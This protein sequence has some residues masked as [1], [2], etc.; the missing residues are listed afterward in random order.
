MIEKTG[1]GRM[2]TLLPMWDS[3]GKRSTRGSPLTDP[4]VGKPH[5]IAATVKETLNEP[6]EPLSSAIREKMEARLGY[7]FSSIRI[8]ADARAAESSDALNARAYTA[9][10]DIAFAEG[11]FN[12]ETVG[13]SELLAHE[14]VHTAQQNSASI[15]T[16]LSVT[17]RTDPQEVG[18]ENRSLPL[19]FL[20]GAYSSIQHV[21]T[22]E[23]AR[24]EP[25]KSRVNPEVAQLPWSLYVDNFQN[26]IYDLSYRAE[27]GNLSTWLT[28]VYADGTQIDISVYDLVG[29]SMSSDGM[30]DLMAGAYVGQ[31]GRI[32]PQRMNPSTTPRLWAARESAIQ[33][34]EEYNYQFMLNTLPAVMFII[35]M[36]LMMPGKQP[37]ATREPISRRPPLLKT[38]LAGFSATENAVIAEA[39]AILSSPQM[40]EIRAAYTAGKSVTVRVGTRIIQFEPGL[41]ASGMTMFGENGFLIGKEA[42][43]SE[44]E[45]TKTI[46][47]EL[48]RLSTSAIGEGAAAS[49]A[50][51]S[52]ETQAAFQFA[53]RAYEAAF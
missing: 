31:G 5:P 24:A 13:G 46:L 42:F 2:K 40:A 36:P 39:K 16:G 3:V 6:G 44:V 37:V 19:P 29:E 50:A 26:V 32:F 1:S 34:M 38:G 49:G 21:T 43:A 41:P 14:L 11:Q 23:L 47:Q 15:G 53:E 22:V 28:V 52:A 10:N 18:A 9:G 8:H 48:Y 20:A 35:T 33:A 12:P 17:E 4:E 30:H 51:V 45:L 25:N 7:D 27:G